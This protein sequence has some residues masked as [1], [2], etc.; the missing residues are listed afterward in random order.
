MP[1]TETSSKKYVTTKNERHT[2]RRRRF[3]T[4]SSRLSGVS[5]LFTTERFCTEIWK[6]RTSF[7]IETC[8]L[9]WGISMFL[10]L[11]RRD[12]ATPRQELLTTQAL[13]CG[14]ICLMTPKVIFGHLD[15]SYMKCVLWFHLLEQTTCKVCTKKWS[16]ENTQE[17]QNTSVRK[18]QQ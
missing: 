17:F 13:R 9:N 12:W 1:T 18:W 4:C 8:K 10:K 2:S 15:V 5:K 6:V 3:G 11:S 7:C 16:K 14:E